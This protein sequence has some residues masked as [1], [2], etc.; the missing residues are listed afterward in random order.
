MPSYRAQ[1]EIEAANL[2]LGEIGEPPIGSLLESS[3][4]ARAVNLWFGTVRD[5]LLRA[6]DWGFAAAWHI[7]AMD[8]KPAIGPYPNRFVM[9]DDC[10]KVRNVANSASISTFIDRASWDLEAAAVGP[11]DAPPSA[12]VLVTRLTSVTV[13]YTRRI[14]QVRLW[15]PQFVAAFAKA[16][17][18]AI[19]PQVAK[20]LN[21]ATQKAA[22]ADEKIDRA[23][24]T[25]SRE[26]SPKHVS[27]DTSWVQSRYMGGTP[28]R[29]W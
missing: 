15:D 20:N 16:L 27:R 2:A 3:G 9:P 29:R 18:A 24:R 8:P 5:D 17:A 19:S 21:A 28:F 22:E 12:V 1:S 11:N 13:S 26:A 10:L 14:T 6:H 25:D 23:T 4:R 7:P